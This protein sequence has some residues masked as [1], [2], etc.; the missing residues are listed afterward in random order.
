M[1]DG[2]A[3]LAVTLGLGGGLALAYLRRDESAGTVPGH[4]RIPGPS[5]KG[6]PEDPRAPPAQ[7]PRT[8]GACSLRLDAKGLTAD[9]KPVDVPGAV[10]HCKVAGKADLV[11]GEDGPASVYVELNRALS[12]AGVAVTVWRG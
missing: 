1:S 10:A 3:F 2:S 8:K 9:G 12:S 7:P 11:F 5:G 6:Q 4:A